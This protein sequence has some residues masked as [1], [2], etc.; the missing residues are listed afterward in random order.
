MRTAGVGSV[1]AAYA[2]LGL[3]PDAPF[4]DART[5]YRDDV[6]PAV[7]SAVGAKR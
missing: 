2:T 4:S 6:V 3:E 1:L 7:R 5:A